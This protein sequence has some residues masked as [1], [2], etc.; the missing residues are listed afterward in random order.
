MNKGLAAYAVEY[1]YQVENKQYRY[2]GN[3]LVITTSVERACEL[4]K[5]HQPTARLHAVHKKSNGEVLFDKD[6]WGQHSLD[7]SAPSRSLV[8]WAYDQHQGSG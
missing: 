5:E 2:N 1:S 4:V 3:T 7:G 8:D 6:Q